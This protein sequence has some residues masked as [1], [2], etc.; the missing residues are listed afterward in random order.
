M[1]PKEHL[2]EHESKTRGKKFAITIFPIIH[3]ADTYI[4]YINSQNVMDVE[5]LQLSGENNKKI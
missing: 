1:G 5:N 4:Q 2:H 3:W